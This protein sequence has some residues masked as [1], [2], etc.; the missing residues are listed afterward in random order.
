VPAIEA[1]RQASLGYL[2]AAMAVT[3]A[4]DSCLERGPKWNETTQATGAPG[5]SEKVRLQQ[6]ANDAM[7]AGLQWQ[8]LAQIV[9][10]MKPAGPD[11]RR[12]HPAPNAGHPTDQ[13]GRPG[14]P[15]SAVIPARVPAS[16]LDIS[17]GTAYKG[18]RVY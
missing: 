13:P 2:T 9:I 3:A 8:R 5:E 14:R 15:I 12:N 4:L 18:G 10:S 1:A 6:L 16:S 7:E 11:N 17:G